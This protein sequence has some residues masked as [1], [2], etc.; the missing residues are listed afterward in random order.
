M[1]QQ[2]L[3]FVRTDTLGDEHTMK[4]VVYY[5]NIFWLLRIVAVLA[6]LSDEH[7]VD[8]QVEAP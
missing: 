4:I 8:M 7:R 1:K 6:I 3:V 2:T 5:E